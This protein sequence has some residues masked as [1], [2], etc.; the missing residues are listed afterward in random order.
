MTQ[1]NVGA[2]ERHGHHKPS[3]RQHRPQGSPDRDIRSR[4]CTALSWHM[5]MLKGSLLSLE[6]PKLVA[7]G[8]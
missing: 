8:L 2:K 3:F 4:L 7:A 5:L 6:P 1:E